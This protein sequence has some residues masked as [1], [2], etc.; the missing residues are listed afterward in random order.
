MGKLKKFKLNQNLHSTEST[1]MLND[2]IDE[3][4]KANNL[5]IGGSG[6]IR[7]TPKGNQIIIPK[8]K[9]KATSG[10]SSGDNV[11][12]KTLRRAVCIEDAPDGNE[13]TAYLY[14]SSGLEVESTITVFC[15]IS[16]GQIA[17]VDHATPAN[18][19]V[20]DTF[21]LTVAL[22]AGGYDSVSYVATN[23]SVSTVC[24]NLALLWNAEVVA[25]F[26]RVSAASL[27]PYVRLT[28]DTP[29]ES[30]DVTGS[31]VNGGALDTQTLTVVTQTANSAFGDLSKATPRLKDSDDIFITKSNYYIDCYLGGCTA[32][33]SIGYEVETRWVCVAQFASTENC[34]CNS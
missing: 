22:D 20:G 1:K 30:F 24:Y 8:K 17:Q 29:G 19:E 16:N 13:I 5:S 6:Y 33:P 34:V 12:G 23:T 4:N 9:S 31:A 14:D 27:G 32:D 11:G 18:V 10:G 7:K 28:A 21:T 15:N 3:I 26:A 2:M 25:E